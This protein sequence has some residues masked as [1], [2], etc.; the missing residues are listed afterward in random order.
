MRIAYGGKPSIKIR[1]AESP[2]QT[3]EI[4]RLA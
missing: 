2:A 4:A 1:F 3:V